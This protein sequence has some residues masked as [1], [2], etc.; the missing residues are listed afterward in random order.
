VKSGDT[1]DPR[2]GVKNLENETNRPLLWEDE[3]PAEIH[4]RRA[5]EDSPLHA[6]PRPSTV[7]RRNAPGM[8]PEYD[9][10]EGDGVA[11]SP[12]A[13]FGTPK[14]RWWRPASTA[15]RAIVGGCAL[16]VLGALTA[17]GFELARYLERDARFSIVGTENI[18]A[19]GLTE[20][21][22]ANLLPVFGEDIGRNIFFVPLSERRRQLEQIP[23]VERATVM[24]VLPNQIRVQVVERHP[25]AFT[26]NGGEIGLVDGNGVLLSMPPKEMAE[27]HYSFP[28]V[29]G[30]RAEDSA[31][32]RRTRMAV[33]RRLIAELDGGGKHNSEQLSEIDLTDPE[34]ARILMSEQGADIVAHFG[35]DHFLER[36][37]RYKSHIGEWR[38]Q[39]PHLAGVDLRYDSQVVL[40][41]T[42]GGETP[43]QP[44]GESADATAKTPNAGGETAAAKAPEKPQSDASKK[45]LTKPAVVA[46]EPV[47][48]EVKAPV[49]LAAK[50]ETKAQSKAKAK[51]DTK[52]KAEARDKTAAKRQ[53]K[54]AAQEKTA[55][56]SAAE[57]ATE[58]KDRTAQKTEKKRAAEKRTAEKRTAEKRTAEE[59]TEDKRAASK[60]NVEKRTTEKRAEDKRAEIKRAEIKRATAGKQNA[61]AVR[62]TAAA[63]KSKARTVKAPESMTPASR[64]HFYS[65]PAS[66]GVQGG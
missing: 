8:P 9:G 18:Q 4:V 62:S 23:W 37:E 43:A 53:E 63:S 25:V 52:V 26:R 66:A 14:R 39:Y 29:T 55:A 34:D 42:P 22:R 45:S 24:R 57:R 50:A 12:M 64:E 30:V 51:V 1:H 58:K 38:Q 47:K 15:G 2:S 7:G 33:Y 27:R 40:Q 17:A 31:D 44:E 60:Q 28:V 59:R 32:A 21:S 65:T 49:K 48:A 36:F 35:E 13:H 54:K 16:L 20:V 11:R 5:G 3:P 6:R 19:A 10:P 56:K 41:M 61:A 46:K